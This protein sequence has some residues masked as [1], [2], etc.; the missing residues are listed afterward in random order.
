DPAAGVLR[1]TCQSCGTWRRRTGLGGFDVLR[2]LSLADPT[3]SELSY[4][5]QPGDTLPEIA[6]RHRTSVADIL[7]MNPLSNPKILP[8]GVFLKLPI[9]SS[10]DLVS[11]TRS[12]WWLD[13]SSAELLAIGNETVYNSRPFFG[14]DQMVSPLD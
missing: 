7:A 11:T 10:Q 3:S 2:R 1:S 4:K 12:V 14:D 8:V 5:V 9:S 6:S 13:L